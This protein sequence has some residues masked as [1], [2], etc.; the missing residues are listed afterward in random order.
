MTPHTIGPVVSL[1]NISRVCPLPMAL[2][3]THMMVIHS[4][5]KCKFMTE[6]ETTTSPAH[7]WDDE[8][9][10]QLSTVISV[11]LQGIRKS[12]QLVSDGRHKYH[13]VFFYK[14]NSSQFQSLSIR[15]SYHFQLSLTKTFLKRMAEDGEWFVTQLFTHCCIVYAFD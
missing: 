10:P 1:Q 2:S 4:W 8:L 14:L 13:T 5:S 11:G 3:Y 15:W 6:H 9:K 12:L 7:S